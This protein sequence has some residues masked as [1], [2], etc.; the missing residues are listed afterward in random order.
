MVQGEYW[1]CGDQQLDCWISSECFGQEV[2]RD[3]S[4]LPID[5]RLVVARSVHAQKMHNNIRNVAAYFH[6]SV[7]SKMK[8]YKPNEGPYSRPVARPLLNGGSGLGRGSSSELVLSQSGVVVQVPTGGHPEIPCSQRSDRVGGSK[9]SGQIPHFI[10]VA[11]E[12]L[13]VKERVG[14]FVQAMMQRL[15]Q[16]VVD[17]LRDLEPSE[18]FQILFGLLISRRDWGDADNF[19]RQALQTLHMLQHPM[20][21]VLCRNFPHQKKK[22]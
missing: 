18:Q 12:Q 15:S 10:T 14:Q 19:I 2:L 1:T 16:P 6:T 20:F 3:L 7:R 5:Q 11:A 21:H 13:F 9:Q 4:A 22:S 8:E 17:Q